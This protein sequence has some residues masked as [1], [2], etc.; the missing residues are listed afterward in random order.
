MRCFNHGTAKGDVRIRVN[1]SAWYDPD[2]TGPFITLWPENDVT[3]SGNC[4][5]APTAVWPEY[6]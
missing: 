1:C 4:W 3:L 6:Q 2:V 5:S